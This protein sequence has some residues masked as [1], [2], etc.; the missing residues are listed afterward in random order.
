[1]LEQKFK[2]DYLWNAI[3]EKR[4][5]SQPKEGRMSIQELNN[6]VIPV[7][8]DFIPITSTIR[9]INKKYQIVN[10]YYNLLN[11]KR[12]L[13]N[14]LGKTFHKQFEGFTQYFM[15]LQLYQYNMVIDEEVLKEQVI[16]LSKIQKNT[17]LFIPNYLDIMNFRY[18]TYNY[19]FLLESVLNK[20]YILKTS[21]WSHR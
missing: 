11:V 14:L 10:Q 8:L 13:Y 3:Q 20:Y 19:I 7:C 2:N 6:L 21:F 16:N 4:T 15:F 1:M 9:N 18:N 12:P 17:I 5:F